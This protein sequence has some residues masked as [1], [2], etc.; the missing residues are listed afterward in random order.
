MT[1]AAEHGL[2]VDLL[3]I[4]NLK[5]RYCAAAD[6]AATDPDG[7]RTMFASV[8][9]A[10]FRGDY[11]FGALDGPE[12]ITDFLCTAI[13]G[14]SEWMLHMVHT[15]DIRIDGDAAEAVW[16]VMAVMQRRAGG[17][18]DTVLGR[19]ADTLRR[20]AEGWRIAR[21]RFIRVA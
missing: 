19:Y 10:D 21:L 13:A 14:N 7:A 17:A 8:F 11:G 16:T 6:L 5:A 9:T 12:A 15:P 3:A 2:A 4:H 1:D 18:R 20:T